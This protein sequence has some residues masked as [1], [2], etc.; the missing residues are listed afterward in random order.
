MIRGDYKFVGFK[1]VAR[2]LDARLQR[3]ERKKHY[4]F[5][6]PLDTIIQKIKR[7]HSVATDPAAHPRP[8]G[9][10]IYTGRLYRSINA[11]I[12]QD[13]GDQ[14]VVQMGYYVPYGVNLE[15]GHP[16][17][18][19]DPREIRRWVWRKYGPVV[20]WDKN[21]LYKISTGI[22]RGLKERGAKPY[23]ILLPKFLSN[24]KRYANSVMARFGQIFFK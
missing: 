7:E 19:P 18:D 11:S 3:Y 8:N 10:H 14:I 1:K 12:I 24:I 6:E 17:F 22:I 20:G 5:V 9:D 4:I 16:P 23:P 2:S 13:T 15:E 21:Q